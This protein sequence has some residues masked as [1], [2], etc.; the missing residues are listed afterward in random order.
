MFGVLLDVS[1]SMRSAYATGDRNH[2]V[3]VQRTHTLFTTI[4]NIVGKEVANHKRQER[5]FACGFGIQEPA[6][7]CN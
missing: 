5:I 4:A 3:S 1:G 2:D 6:P 7:V